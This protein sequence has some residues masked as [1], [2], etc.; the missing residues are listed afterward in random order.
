MRIKNHARILLLQSCYNNLLVK[1]CL[2]AGL[3]FLFTF[4]T[5]AFPTTFDGPVT[6]VVNGVS[7]NATLH[8]VGDFA[9]GR[10]RA[11][12]GPI[13]GNLGWDWQRDIPTGTLCG[14]H[15][16]L[17][18]NGAL[19]GAVLFSGGATRSLTIDYGTG[20]R[21]SL[22]YVSSY[23]GTGDVISVVGKVSGT[24]PTGT[25]GDVIEYTDGW[26]DQWTQ[27]SSNTITMTG[28]RRFR[29]NGGPLQDAFV[30]IT[31]TYNGL[32]Q[33]PFPQKRVASSVL[34]SYSPATG[35]VHFEENNAVFPAAVPTV[36]F[37]GPVT[38][39]VNG[40]TISAN[41][42]IVGNFANGHASASIQGIPVYLGWGWQWN[43]P[44]GTL[45]GPWVGTTN[46]GA[47]NG[48]TLFQNGFTRALS[49]QY[50]SGETFYLTYVSSAPDSNNVVAVSG[51]VSGNIPTGSA[52]DVVE[53]PVGWG[54]QWTQTS[55][56]VITMTG[57]RRFRVNGGPLQDAFVRITNTYDGLIQMPFPQKRIASAVVVS[58]DEASQTVHFDED[59]AIFPRAVQT[60]VIT[61]PSG[62][63]LIANPLDQGNNT[64]ADVFPNM[65][66]GASL[67][68]YSRTSC[69]VSNTYT[70]GSGFGGWIDSIG[71]PIDPDSVMFAPGAGAF[72][73]NPG[74]NTTITFTGTPHVPVLPPIYPC[75][76][77]HSY[78]LSCQTNDLGT[79]ENITGLPAREGARLERWNGS[80][81]TVYTYINAAWSPAV[82]SVNVGESVSVFVPNLPLVFNGL[83]N[84]P[85]GNASIVE[86]TG[87][88]FVD[89]LGS[90]GQ[91][92]VSVTL[93]RAKYCAF[94][95]QPIISPPLGA[96]LT[97]TA[98]GSVAGVTNHGVS[99]V[100]VTHVSSSVDGYEVTADLSALGSPS[101]RL[102]VWNNGSLV[103][104]FPGH[105]GLVAKLA[106]MPIGGG[107]LP[108]PLTNYGCIVIYNPNPGHVWIDNIHYTANELRI[109]QEAGPAP[110]Y[111]SS[112][113]ITGASL[114]S[115]TITQETMVGLP[116]TLNGLVN[117][118]V[119]NASV[120]NLG[121]SGQDGVSIA[122][123]GSS[124]Q[125]GVSVKLGR[126]ESCAFSWQPIN[127]PPLGASLTL[128]ASGSVGGATNHG[129]GTLT[130]T[131]VSNSIDG[132]EVSA[133]LSALESPSQRLELWNNGSL[134]AVFPGHTGLVAKLAAIPTGG[135]KLSPYNPVPNYGCIVIYNP[136]PWHVWINNI[137]YTA[138][139]LRVLQEA[140]PA[141]DYLSD[142]SITAAGLTSLT[143]T[144][145]T[146]VGLPVTL[147]GL[148]NAPVGNASVANIGSSGQ[149]GVSIANLGSSGQ[150][151]VSIK[152][153]RAESCAFSWQPISAPLGASLT[154]TASG[155]VGGA[156]NHGAGTLT[157]THVSNSIDGYEVTADL[158][159]L[160]SPS[161]RL[162][163][164]NNGSLVAVF[165]GH[166][167]P[168][169]R[170]AAMPTGGGKL[171]PYNP[172]TNY[173]CIW[174][175]NPNPWHVWVNGIHFTATELRVLQEAG[176]AP[177]YLSD[178]SLTGATLTS[179]TITQETM[180]GRPVTFNSLVNAP[181]G[182]ASVAN[183]GSSG[184][185]GVSIMNIGSSG[186]DGVSIKLGRA[187]SCAFSWQPINSPPLGATLTLTA[188]GSVGG[189]T[190]HG[191]GT[192][193]VTHV[194]NSVNGYQ[195]TA[196]LSALGSP[197]QRLELWNNG[198]LVA[199][200]PGHT[201]PV[202]QLA[203][204]PIGGGKLPP[205]YN[206][207]TNYGC[208]VIYNP[209][210]WHVWVNGIAFIATEL[211]VLQEAGPAPDY[212]SDFSIT[213]AGLTSL[214]LTQE[215]VVLQRPNLTALLS[216]GNIQIQWGGIGVL[217]QS[218]NLVNWIDISGA[219]NPYITPATSPR[220]FYRSRQ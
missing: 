131:H 30:R 151:G 103:A 187:Q 177:D 195:V 182:N 112:F 138:T 79:Y 106:A 85:A 213:A 191:A 148:V 107:K 17:T 26:T 155:S 60:N 82:P 88:V 99:I 83:L 125:D 32:V 113:S 169:A 58:Y 212:L 126:A 80:G 198:S 144:Q 201:G 102:E 127:F 39:V 4:G 166:T 153:G 23:S 64:L 145:E 167:G 46:G 123:L 2:G 141:P 74:S 34:A 116:A 152:L 53:Y 15:V 188:T 205:I 100:T 20:E 47:L 31:N 132:Y 97:L 104:V 179:L 194:N 65:I 41:L 55:S 57:N 120:A 93:G 10:A 108:P 59:N 21:F 140:G 165:P 56:N 19:N 164:W 161:Q 181:V 14:P 63:S 163:L 75:G 208:I 214:T 98:T 202:A 158:S 149:D 78:I 156:T 160:G 12:I 114:T 3:S 121:S 69:G 13:P 24:I 9:T 111:L 130:V 157:V 105:T 52:G 174:V 62:Y 192:L 119:G 219:A 197:S 86:S 29:V 43:I 146:M 28:N 117:A 37:A 50:G 6:G 45:C 18:N 190:N 110:D 73:Y 94:Y 184:Q 216:G 89:N 48:S 209:N 142:F 175:A 168:V 95:W 61:V 33:M 136:N 92:G 40:Q 196:D 150:D 25:P 215:N 71:V 133:D 77:G 154:L 81:F 1:S 203:A 186:Q 16:A 134:V 76:S 129:A 143:I 66:D 220:K 200:F 109:L 217:Q 173:G 70:Y 180:M 207:P 49:V 193:T 36:M 115:L 122:N 139:E 128:T 54:D 172:V 189:A 35:M 211:R 51:S 67:T 171:A 72:F 7:I 147:N 183:I 199:V 210:P 204:M 124:G 38:G 84:T 96:S 27:T 170:L 91:D 87:G 42:N 218:S 8:I 206:P 22:S 185:D 44:T 162:E 11:D 178:F 135:G 101:Q 137:H 5:A 176:P 159:A 68:I 118:P 90:S